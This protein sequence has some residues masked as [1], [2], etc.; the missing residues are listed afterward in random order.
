MQP[1]SVITPGDQEGQENPSNTTFA[2]PQSSAEPVQQS[3]T[4]PQ[5]QQAQSQSGQ[6]SQP[7]PAPQS[8][9]PDGASEDVVGTQSSFTAS[10][11]VTWSASEYV[12]HHKT[13]S[14]YIGLG[15]LAGLAAAVVFL[16]TRDFI[17]LGSI[18]IVAILFG[19]FA[20]RKPNVLQYALD[21]SG[22][23]I[24]DKHFPYDEFKS[25]SIYDEGGLRSIFLLPLK[26]FMPGLSLYYPPD[27]ED[28]VIGT[29][30]LYLPH[31]E[32]Q[33]DAVDRLMKRVRF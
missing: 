1:G 29:M 19:V 26:R 33:P 7:A 5:S 23:T 15:V 3:A 9:Q 25:F 24:A 22:V 14:W 10:P 20:S 30:S 11:A 18:V 2:S 32:R 21:E 28:E 17:T 31:E 16:M 13:S 8:N 4:A 27:L 12:A 6:E